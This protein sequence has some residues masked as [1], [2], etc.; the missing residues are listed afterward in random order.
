[1]LIRL[2]LYLI[3]NLSKS[4]HTNHTSKNVIPTTDCS[5][6]IEVHTPSNHPFEPQYGIVSRFENIGRTP[7]DGKEGLRGIRPVL[8]GNY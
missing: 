2:T 7:W 5:Q 6:T 4:P 3:S 8:G 1:V